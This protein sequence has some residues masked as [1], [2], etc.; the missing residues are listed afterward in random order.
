MK[1]YHG[2]STKAAER[3]RKHGFS[4]R[5]AGARQAALRGEKVAEL[6]GVYLTT[7]R[8][9]A[10]WYAGETFQPGLNRGG[11]VIEVEVSGRIA[12][13]KELW[14]MRRQVDDALGPYDMWDQKERARRAAVVKQRLQDR[15]YVGVD[16]HDNEFIVFNPKHVKVIRLFRAD[17]QDVIGKRLTI[18]ALLRAGRPDLANVVAYVVTA[19]KLTPSKIRTLKANDVVTVYHSTWMTELPNLIN[20]FD[21]STVHYRLY[22]GPKHAGLFIA[23]SE[24]SADKFGSNVMLEIRTKAKFLHGT[25]YSGNI[26]R[27]TLD[28]ETLEWLH[29]KYPDSFRPGLSWSFE[30]TGEPQALLIGLVKPRQIV[31]VRHAKQWYTRKE[32]LDQGFEAGDRFSRKPITDVGHDLSY[33]NYSLDQLSK[34]L[35]EMFGVP[36]KRVVEVLRKAKPENL[37]HDFRNYGFGERAI[38]KYVKM[39]TG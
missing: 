37:E 25:D 30:Q 27:R 15:G 33:P 26:G 9:T 21:A 34:I 1:A 17:T 14:S 22:G 2:T 13:S 32:F 29:E 4:L 38:K 36:A 31:R 11:V 7:E 6:S 18:A 39:L 12:P 3:I 28:E 23:P 16:E 20:G 10:D 5:D 8:Q 24:Q 35:S 19:S